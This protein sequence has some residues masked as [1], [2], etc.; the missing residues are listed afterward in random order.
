M[1][2]HTPDPGSVADLADHQDLD[3]AIAKFHSIPEGER[4]EDD[5]LAGAHALI[6]RMDWL[7]PARREEL[8]EALSLLLSMDKRYTRVPEF[9]YLLG[10]AYYQLEDYQEAIAWYKKAPDTGLTPSKQEILSICRKALNRPAEKDSFRSRV[11]RSWASFGPIEGELRQMMNEA[12]S[13]RKAEKKMISL[14]SKQVNIAIP[15]L[16]WFWTA[17]DRPLLQLD[18][19]HRKIAALLQQHYLNCAPQAVQDNWYLSV[20]ERA[21]TDEDLEE[22]RQDGGY[23]SD[24]DVQ[25]RHVDADLLELDVFYP[26][27]KPK[28]ETGK[29]WE[30]VM[31]K[32]LFNLGETVYLGV[33]LHMKLCSTPPKGPTIKLG[34]LLPTLEAMGLGD[35]EDRST[36]LYRRHQMKRLPSIPARNADH[37]WRQDVFRALTIDPLLDLFYVQ[38]DSAS[39][40]EPFLIG[41]G[42]VAGFAVFPLKGQTDNP[43]VLMQDLLKELDDNMDPEIALVLGNAEGL[44]F[45]YLDLVAWDLQPAL[46]TVKELLRRHDLPWACWH[47]FYTPDRTEQLF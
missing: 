22:L 45:G 1:F 7:T 44:Q 24:L 38:G 21:P 18:P 40:V 47:P 26:S 43:P 13:N 34:Q 6:F 36:T 31:E 8:H 30:R 35:R 4:T 11:Q 15:D 17:G 39:Y 12:D 41:T 29:A 27:L 14:V 28:E 33:F 10:A 19:E 20:G 3:A 46:D 32:L 25:I 16:R 5:V 37:P 23:L 2:S 9:C 42:A